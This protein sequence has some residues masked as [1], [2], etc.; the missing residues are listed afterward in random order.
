MVKGL[1][2]SSGPINIHKRLLI[3]TRGPEMEE[4]KKSKATDLEII[5]AVIS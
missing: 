3:G 1:S 4:S 2:D 5:A